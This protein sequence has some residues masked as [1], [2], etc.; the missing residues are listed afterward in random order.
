MISSFF[1][2]MRNNMLQPVRPVKPEKWEFHQHTVSFLGFIV[3][4]GI[5]QRLVLLQTCLLPLIVNSNS[6]SETKALWLS[7]FTFSLPQEPGFI[8][9]PK[10]KGLSRLLN[11]GSPLHLFLLDPRLHCQ[12]WCFRCGSGVDATTA[13]FLSQKVVSGWEELW[14]GQP[15]VA[16]SHPVESLGKHSQSCW[17]GCTPLILIITH[18]APH[19]FTF[20]FYVN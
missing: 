8:G 14:R 20:N 17:H 12:C 5:I 11:T 3:C 9:P 7:I 16:G 6:L 2:R 10:P 19:K 13:S 1:A 4:P 18:K 15:D